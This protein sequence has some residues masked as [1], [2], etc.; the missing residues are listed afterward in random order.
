V[1]SGTVG[2]LMIAFSAIFVRLADVAPSTAAVYRCAYALPVLAAL[3]AREQRR[4]GPRAP[5][6]RRAALAAGVFF[7]IDL[8]FWHHAIAEV[9]AGLATVLANTQV[10]IV[11]IVAWM[12]L[13]ERPD[14]RLLTAVP[15]VL[16][17]VVLISGAVGGG[18]YGRNPGLG[19]IY[20]LVTACAYAGFLLLLRRGNRDLRRP[21]GPL[22]EASL[23]AAV[24]SGLAGAAAGDLWMSP[25][26]PAHGWL[27]VLALTNQ[28]VAWLLISVSLPRLP[29][30]VTS[31][32]LLLQPVA[33]VVLGV[34]LLGEDP[35]PV[36]GIG[37]VVVAGGIL[38]ASL[39]QGNR[40]GPPPGAEGRDARPA[41]PWARRRSYISAS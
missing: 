12:V 35:S 40:D 4:Y 13:G 38:L 2:A 22:F 25:S 39:R 33:S 31:V 15:V 26:W 28:V 3:A 32:L 19:V 41:R 9:G 20:G 16:L 5:A 17:G 8:T 14:R 30:L 36:Q 34:V 27:L 6:D 23:V 18:A 29:A 7:A 1:L 24:V 21:A 10:V 11:G 37:V